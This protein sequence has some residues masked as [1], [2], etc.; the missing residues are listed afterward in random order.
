V[1]RGQDLRQ[2]LEQRP[3]DPADGRPGA[4]YTTAYA[5]SWLFLSRLVL[6]RQW[7]LNKRMAG[8]FISCAIQVPARLPAFPPACL[9]ARSTD[10]LTGTLPVCLPAC[11]PARL[12]H[13]C[14]TPA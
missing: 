10:P 12:Q 2:E 6:K 13:P 11:L 9:P 4:L 5:N 8:F 14:L 7:L 3:F 1:Q